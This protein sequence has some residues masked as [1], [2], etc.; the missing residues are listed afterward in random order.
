MTPLPGRSDAPSRLNRTQNHLPVI[1]PLPGDNFR[2]AT[3]GRK[4]K[5]GALRCFQLSSKPDTHHNFEMGVQLRR[6]A[7][8]RGEKVKRWGTT[9]FLLSSK[10]DTHHNTHGNSLLKRTPILRSFRLVGLKDKRFSGLVLFEQSKALNEHRCLRL[11]G[12]PAGAL[13]SCL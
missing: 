4:S 2:Q 11:Q 8:D 12:S 1:L 6:S 5:D 7:S 3:E 10:A 13:L 9:L